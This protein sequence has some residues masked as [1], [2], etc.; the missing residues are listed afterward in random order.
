MK[1]SMFIDS[2][3]MKLHLHRVNKLLFIR[4]NVMQVLGRE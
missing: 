3:P 2:M 1:L 4:D